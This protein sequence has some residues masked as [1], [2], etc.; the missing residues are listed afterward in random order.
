MKISIRIP[1][2]GSTVIK[3]WTSCYSESASLS[4]GAHG[5]YDP[6]CKTHNNSLPSSLFTIDLYFLN[7]NILYF[8]DYFVVQINIPST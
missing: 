1:D 5:L 3:Y 6:Q 7:F 4:Q 8:T 2:I